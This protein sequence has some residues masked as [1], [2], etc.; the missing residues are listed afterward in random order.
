MSRSAPS[1]DPPAST[2]KGLP[3]IE[4]DEYLKQLSRH[5][6]THA[7]ALAAASPGAPRRIVSSSGNSAASW[8][9]LGSSGP[10]AAVTLRLDPHHLFW[11]LLKY[12]ELG[13]DVG[14]LDVKAKVPARPTS[15]GAWTE[16]DKS[17]TASIFSSMSGLSLG[18]GWFGGKGNVAKVNIK[19]ETKYLFST[20]TKL[21][22]LRLTPTSN[23]T[24]SKSGP[25]QLVKG[26]EDLPHENAV[27]LGCFKNLQVLQVEDLDPRSFIGW[28]RLSEG[29]RSLEVRRTGLEDVEHLLVDAVVGDVRRRERRDRQ[30]QEAEAE[31]RDD[32]GRGSAAERS[33]R[34][35]SSTTSSSRSS[36]SPPT[37]LPPLAWRFLRHL[38]LADNALT[39]LP[40]GPLTALVSL[41]SLDLSSNLLIAVPAGLSTLT[42]LRSLSLA[43]NMIESVLG[44]YQT[45]G[46]VRR[47]VP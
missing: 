19:E 11:L 4:G 34:P 43:D 6:R 24:S 23:P 14:P 18:S 26:F 45:I 9:G 25:M 36:R 13:I 35:P 20:F 46:N 21:P 10:P 15:Y 40:T 5:I 29:L 37:A 17:E 3:L 42:E 38:C 16:K 2:S 7:A 28:D 33:L 47:L 44:I 8:I 1:S 27:P 41:A 31:R 30:R 39:F 12:E 32:D 22:A